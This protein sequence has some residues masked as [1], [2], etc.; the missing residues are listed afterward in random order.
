MRFRLFAIITAAIICICSACAD[1]ASVVIVMSRPLP[2]YDAAQ[3]GFASVVGGQSR[4]YV[5]TGEAAV[6]R[7]VMAQIR[8]ERPD[9]VLALGT[10][11]ATQVVTQLGGTPAVFAMVVDPVQSGLISNPSRPGGNM[12]GVTLAVPASE[13]IEALR[14]AL[15]GARRVGVIYDPAQSQRLVGEMSDAARSAGLQVTSR[16][17][18]SA[19]E[20]PRAAEELRGRVDVLYAQVD[21]TVYSPQSARFVLLF[22]LRNRIPVIG[23]SAN[24]A[25]AG[26]LLAVYPD[27]GDVGRQA[28]YLAQRILGGEAPGSIAV[29]APRRALLAINLNVERTLGLTLS[30]SVRRSADKVFR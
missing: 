14:R 27:Y 15:P 12:T 10:E 20:V 9:L 13:T 25:E 16:A 19:A 7:R 26:A 30:S 6:T 3:Q 17:V 8:S 28:G 5:L 11:A 22:A 29:A 1:A 24:L 21:A 2:A 18:H 23:F 4:C